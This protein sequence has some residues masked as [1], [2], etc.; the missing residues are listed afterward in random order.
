MKALNKKLLEKQIDVFL[1]CAE[2]ATA[3]YKEWLDYFIKWTHKENILHVSNDDVDLF[4]QQVD[5]EENATYRKTEARRAIFSFRRYYMARS[6]NGKI[7]M[8]EGRP[9]HISQIEKAQ[10][11]RKHN[12]LSLNE[13]GKLL[14]GIDKSQIHRWLKYPLE[15]LW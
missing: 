10:K 2:N 5:N 11:Y 9:P 7:R 14:G 12:K 6:K 13:I 4:L 8:R 3:G 1:C 15:K